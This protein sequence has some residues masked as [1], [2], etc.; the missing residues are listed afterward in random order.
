MNISLL[1]DEKRKKM[2]EIERGKEG[3]RKEK[4]HIDP[5]AHTKNE[6]RK[7]SQDISQMSSENIRY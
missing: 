6:A 3:M 1:K 4:I 2:K 5:I 7:N